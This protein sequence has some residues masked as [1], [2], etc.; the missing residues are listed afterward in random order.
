MEEKKKTGKGL[1]ALDQTALGSGRITI[2]GSVKIWWIEP[3]RTRFND[4][5]G[6]GARLIVGLDDLTGLF[7]P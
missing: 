2:P 1:K 4:E 3:L 7:K 6:D 5:H